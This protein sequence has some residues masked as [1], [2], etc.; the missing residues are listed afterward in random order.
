LKEWLRK[1]S[2]LVMLVRQL[3][4]KIQ[5]YLVAIFAS[6]IFVFLVLAGSESNLHSAK[7]VTMTSGSMLRRKEKNLM[8]QGRQKP[9]SG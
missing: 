3:M 9:N 2:W 8:P 4:T 6:K 5:P 1:L 7:D